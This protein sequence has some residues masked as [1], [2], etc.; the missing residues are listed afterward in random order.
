[1][2]THAREHNGIAQVIITLMPY[3]VHNN[4]ITL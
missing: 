4:T 3:L 2:Y 1:M